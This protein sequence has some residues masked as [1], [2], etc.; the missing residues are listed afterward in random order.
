[1]VV[2]VDDGSLQKPLEF[3][4]LNSGLHSAI[5]RLKCNVGHQ[6]ALAI[7]LSWAAEIVRPEQVI[8]AMDCDGED[9]PATIFQLVSALESE[10]IDVVVAERKSRVESWRFKIFYAIYRIFFR[11]MTGRNMSFGNFMA[12]KPSAAKRLV[13]MKDLPI[14]LAGSVLASKLRTSCC[15]IDR[16]A[17]FA[18]HSKMNFFSLA[19]HGFKALMVFAENVLVRVGTACAMIAVLSILGA[20]TA[21][22]LKLLGYST[23]GWFSVAL[24]ILVLMFLQTGAITL[25][26][27][28]LTG[29]VRS[30]NA[31]G[32][33]AYDELIDSIIESPRTNAKC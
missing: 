27:L 20:L 18:G 3:D 12:L 8:V 15:Q 6:H 30:G 13:S 25:M 19:L 29:V 32:K 31:G 9:A 1:L 23:P 7:G 16:G 5:I 14:H 2:A 11:V 26:T 33:H 10:G 17:R 22:L 28:M 24:G 21:V 4:H